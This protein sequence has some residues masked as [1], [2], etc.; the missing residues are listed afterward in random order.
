MRREV[1][2]SEPPGANNV[3]PDRRDTRDGKGVPL[4]KISEGGYIPVACA[5]LTRFFGH[6][7]Y[8]LVCSGENSG[9]HGG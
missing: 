6:W 2:E 9:G 4:H 7:S 1:D 3:V 5:G 8:G